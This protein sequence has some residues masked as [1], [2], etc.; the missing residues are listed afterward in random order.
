MEREERED[1]KRKRNEVGEG[2]K[3]KKEVICKGEG[4]REGRDRKGRNRRHETEKVNEKGKVR[5]EEKGEKEGKRR[6]EGESGR[7]E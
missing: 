3:G 7:K 4:E 2:W 6:M 1:M 5:K